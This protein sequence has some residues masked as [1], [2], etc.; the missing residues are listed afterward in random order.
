M[1][2]FGLK[3]LMELGPIMDLLLITPDQVIL[4]VK[5]EKIGNVNDRKKGSRIYNCSSLAS[6]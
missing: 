2:I 5:G 4:P 1:D 3:I 6:D